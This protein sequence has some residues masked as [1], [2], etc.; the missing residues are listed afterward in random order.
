MDVAVL[1]N[2][3]SR[4]GSNVVADRARAEI[5][6]ARILATRSLA[7]TDRFIQELLAST[8]DLVLSA[9]GDGTAVGLINALRPGPSDRQLPALGL[10]PLGTGNGWANATRAPGW[11]EGLAR[12]G[13]M[14]RRD[15]VLSTR[16]FDL[17]ET[18]GRIAPFAGTGWD[19]E[20]ID[21]FHAQ[22][23][24]FGLLPKGSRNGVAGYLQGLFTRTVPRHVMQR[25]R[26]EV[27]LVNT[28]ED[29][30]TVD[31]TGRP[32]PLPGGENG[33]VLYRGPVGVCGA[34]TSAEWGFGFKSYPFAGKMPRRL[35]VRVYSAGPI[36][37]VLRTR[38][39]WRGTHP[40][41]KMHTWMLTSCKM[42]FSRPMPFQI[43]GDRH[44]HVTEVDYRIAPETID[45]LDWPALGRA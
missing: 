15:S 44:G 32:I 21:D 26:L 38:D 13:A 20:L 33:A 7:E 8:P 6:S 1:V 40:L 17:V 22:K 23:T 2:L 19:A 3:R 9:G 4:R 10:L 43:G 14:A 41:P 18:C 27:E 30:F 24:A 42:T 25:D 28:G 31:D 5:P 34:A 45:V 36:E 16:R 35:C 39:L 11:R 12:V 29:A 37:A